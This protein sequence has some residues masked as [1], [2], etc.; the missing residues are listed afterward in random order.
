MRNEMEFIKK[1]KKLYDITNGES[2]IETYEFDISYMDD[3]FDS[4]K[5]DKDDRITS[6]TSQF[7]IDT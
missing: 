5:E 6:S 1:I 4:D 2:V 7:I 3:D